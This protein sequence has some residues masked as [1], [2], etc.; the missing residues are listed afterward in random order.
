MSYNKSKKKKRKFRKNSNH[1]I[2]LAQEDLEFLVE[3]TKFNAAE[4]SEWHS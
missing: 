1:E 3:K 2:K 4:I